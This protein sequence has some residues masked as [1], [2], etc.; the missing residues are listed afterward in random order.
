MITDYEMEQIL[1][2]GSFLEEKGYEAKVD[3]YGVDYSNGNIKFSFGYPPY[4]NVSQA[5]ISFKGINDLFDLGWIAFVREKVDVDAKK[6]LL[7]LLAIL[8]FVKGHYKEITDYSY[9][10]QSDELI[11][12]YV[13]Q[14]R[15]K[16]E[17]AIQDFLKSCRKS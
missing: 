13:E 6:K 17:K 11:D 10:K 1:K 15:E 14:H 5:S 2:A 7:N 3:E 9:C 16:Y 12:R 8:E 4:E